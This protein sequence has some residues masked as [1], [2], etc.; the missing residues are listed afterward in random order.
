MK[1]VCVA[2]YCLNVFALI[3]ESDSAKMAS[4]DVSTL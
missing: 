1:L 3:S 2:G 4:H